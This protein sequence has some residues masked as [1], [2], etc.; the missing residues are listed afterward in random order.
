MS[1]SRGLVYTF[2][3]TAL[4]SLTLFSASGCA[5]AFLM[6]IYLIYGTDA[7][8]VYKNEMKAIPKGSKMV[9]ICRSNL[10]LFGSAN[11]NA[12]LAQSVT[13]VVSTEMKDKKKKKLVWIPYAEVEDRFD[14][15]ELNSLSFEKMGH[16]LKADYVIGVEI[17]AF[18]IHHSTQFF[19]GNAKVLVRMIRVQDG[20]TVVRQSMPTYTYPANPI[21]RSEYDEIEFQKTFTVRLAR[22]IATLFCPHD[23]HAEYATDS[24]FSNR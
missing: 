21:P 22:N 19:Q 15:E 17:D 3:L 18:D 16:E 13:Y 20:E 24:D 9:V 12:D 11:P 1:H 23:P 8:A 7:P 10:N 2:A 4:M 6:P 5:G 14:E